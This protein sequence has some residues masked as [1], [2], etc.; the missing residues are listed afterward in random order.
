MTGP[1]EIPEPTA[2]RT[3][4]R[5]SRRDFLNKS[6]GI[7]AALA[8]FSVGLPPGRAVASTDAPG[9]AVGALHSPLIQPWVARHNLSA[10]Q[11]EEE[12]KRLKTEGYRLLD[13]CGYQVG[14]EARYAAIWEKRAGFE[15]VSN[16]AVSY[17][18]Y[19]RHFDAYQG[20]FR[21]V[22]LNGYNIAG[23]VFFATI[24]EATQSGPRWWSEASS[25]PTWWSRHEVKQSELQAVFNARDGAGDRMVDISA[26]PGPGF[27]GTQFAMIW[28]P[29]RGQHWGWIPPRVAEYYQRDFAKAVA[30]DY[31]PARVSAF[32]PS[33]SGQTA[34][35]TAVL[36]K[37]VKCPFY[38]RH[39]ISS[40]M[41]Q[42]EVDHQGRT[43]R[44]VFVGGFT[45]DYGGGRNATQ[46]FSPV[47]RR[48][49]AD[50]VVPPLTQAYMEKF[51]V[52]G[53]SLAFAQQGRLLYAGGFGLADKETGERVT[54][55]SLFR[56]ASLSKQITS[57]A[58]LRLVEQGRIRI[59]DTVFGRSG[60]LG[61][62]YGTPS[63]GAGVESI[64]VQ[65]LLEHT[66]G[67][68]WSHDD[69]DP[70]AQ[71]PGLDQEQ[72]ISWVLD[73][74]PL[75][76]AGGA[77]GTEFA[78]SNF[79]YVV[80]GRIIERV[81]TQSYE[82]YVRQEILAPCGISR[83]FLAGNTR[84]DKRAGEV[85]YY[86]QAGEDPYGMQL[87]RKDAEG[88]WLATPVD[89]MRFVT[90]VDGFPERPDILN[91][92]SVTTM[93]TPSTAKGANGYAKGWGTD[94]ATQTWWHLGELPGTSSVVAR[95]RHGICWAAVVN[96]RKSDKDESN[97]DKNTA[98]GL[99]KM[100]W[101]IH[102]QVDAWTGE[103][104]L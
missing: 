24:W 27:L 86:G 41:Y 75:N 72:L 91:Q 48:C 54:T 83:M 49:E 3:N 102:S 4:S 66:A 15:Q 94:S 18:Q 37:S 71:Q 80:L 8:A 40:A 95:T 46:G 57:A 20:S 62:T 34:Y 84:A 35:F 69:P 51:S 52:P 1:S 36:E 13:L 60:I 98:A 6:F 77:P 53:L 89:L 29:A 5:P 50:S 2:R 61:T 67:P 56:I 21:L 99:Y 22:R 30:Q 76:N 79:G 33:G 43:Y 31:R 73:N 58:I 25:A 59:S 38:A 23:E 92:A 93:T 68:G 10:T 45:A 19:G 100:M 26:Y 55:S 81:T 16:H 65:N 90:R 63:Y 74:R 9:G 85:T 28:E 78:Y 101:D 39:G 47:W 42:H 44:P 97:A 88:G 104:I 70:M 82:A 11:Y 103:G 14:N 87:T 64:T 12:A 32:L 7:T 96:T 17:S